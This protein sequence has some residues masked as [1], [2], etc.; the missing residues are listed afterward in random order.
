MLDILFITD[1]VCPY[2]LVAKEA[3]RQALQETGLSAR[4]TLQ[5]MEL[6]PEGR[7]QVDTYNDPVR[8]SHYQVLVEPCEALGLDMKLPPAVIPRP[9]TRLAFEG[10]CFA[11]ENGCE[12]AYNDLMYKAYFIDEQDI[13]DLDVLCR[14]AAG[15]GLDADKYREMLEYG[16]YSDYQAEQN[17][18]S[19]EQYQPEGIPTIYIN[20]QKVSIEAY[21]VEEMTGILKAFASEETDHLPSS[22]TGFTGCGPD[23]C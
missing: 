13:G 20:G 4:I 14:L 5:P 23:G 6:S 2:C 15:L 3:L 17:R 12:E 16:I 18:I 19:R 10:R 11:I 1:Y 8:R 9:R 21:T 22:A 7:P